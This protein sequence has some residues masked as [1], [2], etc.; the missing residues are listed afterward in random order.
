M[1]FSRQSWPKETNKL[2]HNTISTS[3]PASTIIIIVLSY[4]RVEKGAERV[5]RWAQKHKYTKNRKEKNIKKIVKKGNNNRKQMK[6]K[7][8]EEKVELVSER[9][10]KFFAH[11]KRIPHKQPLVVPLS[12]LF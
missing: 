11:T 4:I 12:T 1:I 2:P 3:S 8:Q 6:M 7:E 9:A 10:A 5:H